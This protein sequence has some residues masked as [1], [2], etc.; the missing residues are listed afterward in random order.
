MCNR[1]IKIGQRQLLMAFSQTCVL[2]DIS[3]FIGYLIYV[4]TVKA[5][6]K[7]TVSAALSF[8]T[9]TEYVHLTV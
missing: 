8:F 4:N 9:H 1:V 7:W 5:K 6:P 2:F 3:M